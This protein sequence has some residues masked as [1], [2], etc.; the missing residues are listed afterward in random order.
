MSQWWFKRCTTGLCG[1]QPRPTVASA[2]I[3]R[4]LDEHQQAVLEGDQIGE[5]DKQPGQPRHPTCKVSLAQ[6]GH[7]FS[8]PYDGHTATVAVAKM[9]QSVTTQTL[10][11]QPGY[12]SALLYGHWRHA[13]RGRPG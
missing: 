9:A 7:S 11:D 4:P 2:V 13:G 5:V 10:V 8:A 6:I 1:N 3:A 12:V